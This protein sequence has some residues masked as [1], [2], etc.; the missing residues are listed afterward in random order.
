MSSQ[1]AMSED[2]VKRIV[3]TFDKEGKPQVAKDQLEVAIYGSEEVMWV[4]DRPFR[5]D[6]KN[7]S[8]FYEDQFNQKYSRSGLVRR[9][10]LPSKNRAYKYSIEANGKTLDPQIVI[11]PGGE[12]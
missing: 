9:S 3:I 7:V 6:F 1:P 11:F 2:R 12:G 4:C 5:I 10:V 8:P